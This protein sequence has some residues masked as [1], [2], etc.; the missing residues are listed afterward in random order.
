MIKVFRAI[1]YLSVI[2]IFYLS[3]LPASQL[4]YFSALSFVG[5][6]ISHSIIFFYIS[7]LGM[8]CNFKIKNFNLLF[9]VFLFG[10][11]IEMIH[12]FHPNRYFEF[13]D[14]LANLLGIMLARIIYSLLRKI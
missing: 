5:D 1:F 3:L 4:T 6:K 13:E 8:L 14:L 2:S 9:L 12:Y 10:L 11:L 7:I